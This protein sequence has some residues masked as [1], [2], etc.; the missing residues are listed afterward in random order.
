MVPTLKDYHKKMYTDTYK[1]KTKLNQFGKEGSQG[2]VNIF[3]KNKSVI[4]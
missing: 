2:N 4:C 3:Y 1:V